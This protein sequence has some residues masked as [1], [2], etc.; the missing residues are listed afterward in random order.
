M[1]FTIG[2]TRT[3]SF[4]E[5][6]QALTS[7]LETDF[8]IYHPTPD[9]W[10]QLLQTLFA[11]KER[12][13]PQETRKL[14]LVWQPL[15]SLRVTGTVFSSVKAK[16]DLNWVEGRECLNVCHQTLMRDLHAVVK[17]PLNLFKVSQ[18]VQGPNE[19]PWPF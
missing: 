10:Q 16:G 6:P 12:E 14:V 9:D 17:Q 1:S 18:V 11:Y 5:K 19:T 8:H 2:K 13:N 3:F 15:T 4:S 7:L